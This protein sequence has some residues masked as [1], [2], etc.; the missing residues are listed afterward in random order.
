MLCFAN[1][2]STALAFWLGMRA[3]YTFVAG[4]LS[5]SPRFITMGRLGVVVDVFNMLEE[6]ARSLQIAMAT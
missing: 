2:G 1:S 6:S 5:S 4:S 3:H